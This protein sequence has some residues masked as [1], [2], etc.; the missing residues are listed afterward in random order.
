MPK[1]SWNTLREQ[2]GL[3][4]AATASGPD[5]PGSARSDNESQAVYTR[6]RELAGSAVE[7]QAARD[8]LRSLAGSRR[9]TLERA[10]KHSRLGRQHLEDSDQ[11]NRVHRLLYAA[12]HDK[13]V[14]PASPDQLAQIAML[15]EIFATERASAEVWDQLLSA[16]PRLQTL[17]DGARRGDFGKNPGFVVPSTAQLADPEQAQRWRESVNGGLR[18]TAALK[19]VI[20]PQSGESDPLAG[21][22]RAFVFADRHLKS[23]RPT[24]EDAR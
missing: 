5:N 13:P 2:V 24:P 4:R 3:F 20:G 23:E 6:A 8:E 21:S 18:L 15:N 10:E 9:K 22:V 17:L 1:G 11:A 14:A 19:H 12:L 16:Q 7:D